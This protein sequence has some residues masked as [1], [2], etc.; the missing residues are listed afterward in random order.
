LRCWNR[1]SVFAYRPRTN[2][3]ARYEPLNRSAVNATENAN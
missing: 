3:D 1:V 2:R